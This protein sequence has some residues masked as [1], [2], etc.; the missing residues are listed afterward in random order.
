[1]FIRFLAHNHENHRLQKK[2]NHENL[3][4]YPVE[5][6]LP[7]L[8]LHYAALLHLIDTFFSLPSAATDEEVAGNAVWRKAVDVSK[9]FSQTEGSH[10][11]PA[12]KVCR[13][14]RVL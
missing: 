1:M 14:N 9:G 12:A 5:I 2:L 6:V 10:R 13:Q 4:V 3:V 8:D 11:G 7:D